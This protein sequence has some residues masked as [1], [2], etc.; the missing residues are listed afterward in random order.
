[1]SYDFST[2]EKPQGELIPDK[3]IALLNFQ[4]LAGDEHTPENAFVVTKTG[5]YQLVL[6]ATVVEGDYARRKVW[7]RLTMGAQSG[8]EMSEG[9]KKGVAISGSFLRS[10]LETARGVAPTDESPNAIAARKIDS[11]FEINGMEAW[12]EIGIEKGTGTFS[13]KNRINKIVNTVAAAP[14]AAQ[15]PAAP[16]AARPAAPA[17]PAAPA[18]RPS[19]SWAS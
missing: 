3:T 2:A 12:C 18:A 14:G 16:A 1:M 6:E 15:R 11:L 13:D 19:P 9:Q 8:V 5:L 17:K 4:V 10:L 7:H